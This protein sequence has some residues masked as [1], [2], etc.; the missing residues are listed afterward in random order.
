M[1]AWLVTF[2]AAQEAENER[3]V[4]LCKKLLNCAKALPHFPFTS[5]SCFFLFMSWRR[6]GILRDTGGRGMVV[7]VGVFRAGALSVSVSV[8]FLL[9]AAAGGHAQA[10][11]QV[12]KPVTGFVPPFEI[13]RTVRSAGFDPLAPPLREGTTYVLRATDFR[14][15][16]MRVVVDARTGAIRDVNRIVPGP[17]TSGQLGMVP[18]PYGVPYRYDSPPYGAPPEFDAP[19]PGLGPAEESAAPP[20]S[21]PPRCG[22]P[23]TRARPRRCRCRV[24]GHRRSHRASPPTGSIPLPRLI[25]KP[26]PIP[27]RS[28]TRQPSRP[29]PQPLRRAMRRRSPRSTIDRHSGSRL[30]RASE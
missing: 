15:I 8:S 6:G 28:L 7:R 30:W 4:N 16:L 22:P 12:P 9:L 23:R 19:A 1:P 13:M 27:I 5:F 3:F 20:L 2:P 10:P 14:G 26:T 21:Q 11:P 18:P 17:G 24:R 29:R 25:Q